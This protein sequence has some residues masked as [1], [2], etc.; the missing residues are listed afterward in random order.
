MVQNACFTHKMRRDFMDPRD[1]D[2]LFIEHAGKAE[3]IIPLSPQCDAHRVDA[4]DPCAQSPR[5]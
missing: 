5:A 3:Q 1:G 2:Q 4:A